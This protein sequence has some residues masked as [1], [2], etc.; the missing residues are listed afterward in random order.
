MLRLH[1]CARPWQVRLAQ[2]LI[3]GYVDPG[4]VYD[5]LLHQY[6]PLSKTWIDAGCGDNS[7][8]KQMPEYQG[9]AA[10][11]DLEDRK[12]EKY[13]RGDIYQIPLKDNSA[14]FISSRW[15]AEH[16]K[17]PEAALKEL[18]R[19]LKPGGRLLIRTTS[20]WHYISLFSLSAPMRLKRFLSP[21]PVFPTFFR[22]NDRA[23]YQRYFAGHP[24]W[25]P[26][27][28]LY[29]ENLQYQSPPGY[30]FSVFYH[31]MI[32]RLGLD[33]LKTTII[34]EMTKVQP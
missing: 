11:F 2:K 7:D 9:L 22:F 8:I 13:L 32:T 16:L 26:D 24:G 30:F 34:L 5:D 21:V 31:L 6:V 14:D 1:P 20:K 23:A 19:V 17:D 27:R 3:P 15:V 25:R 12:Q 4:Y 33:R 28:I 18:H 10:G 29:I